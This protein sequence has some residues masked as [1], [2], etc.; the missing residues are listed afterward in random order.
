[1][2][3]VRRNADLPAAGDWQ[4]MLSMA[5]QLVASGLLPAHIKTGPAAVA[6]MLKGRELGIPAMHAIQ[7]IVY[8]QG[9]AT[10]NSE[11]ML[12]LIYRDHGDDAWRWIEQSDTRAACRYRRRSWAEYGE[13]DFTI[14]QARQ[15][16][17]LTGGNKRTW[18]QYPAAMLRAR[19][20]SAVAR[21]VYPDS[22]G[23]MYTPEELGADISVDREGSFVV[24]GGAD[25]EQPLIDAAG[26]PV[27]DPEQAIRQAIYQAQS[28][29]SI[30]HLRRSWVAA[31]DAGVLDDAEV[32]AAFAAAQER[33][34]ATQRDPAPHDPPAT[35]QRELITTQG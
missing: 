20:I 7:N 15:A 12:A 13:W 35:G 34:G 28:S 25:D 33:L 26:R 10:A 19:C 31:R 1:M 8:I 17:L 3:L 11:L 16:G 22:I 29:Q 30:D 5:D 23:G 6:I 27:F 24:V 9:R 21:A 14:E 18:E 32:S 4:T 2:E